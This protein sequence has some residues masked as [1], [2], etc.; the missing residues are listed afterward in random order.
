MT[1]QSV[2]LQMN[3][4]VEN[5]EREESLIV[6]EDRLYRQGGRTLQKILLGLHDELECLNK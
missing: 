1:G 2:G 6:T 3:I 5:Q 4:E